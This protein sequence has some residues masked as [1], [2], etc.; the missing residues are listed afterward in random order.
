MYTIAVFNTRKDAGKTAITINLGHAIALAGHQVTLVDLDPV[1]DLATGL[2]LFRQPTQGIDRVLLESAEMESVAISTRDALHLIPAGSRLM[3]LERQDMPAGR[4]RGLLL[5]QALAGGMAGQEYLIIDCPSSSG[6]LVVNAL[7]GVDMVLMP[8][9][10]DEAGAAG[11]PHLLDTVRQFGVTRGGALDH[12]VLMN[13]IPLRR[14]LTGAAASKFS[15]L[16]PGHFLKSV[17]CQSELIEASRGIGRTV[18]EYRPNSRS[19]ADFRQLATELL[20]R[21]GGRG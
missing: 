4:Q 17:I 14:R 9:T 18:F 20:G 16:A 6:L 19:V 12:V 1:G 11:L 3:E 7:L 13:R 2:G 21:I 8:V 5:Q 10:G 15:S